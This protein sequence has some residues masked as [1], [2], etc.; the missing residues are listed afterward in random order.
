ML[1]VGVGVGVGMILDKANC[2]LSSWMEYEEEAADDQLSTLSKFQNG[3]ALSSSPLK[4][5]DD[6]DY[7]VRQS[8]GCLLHCK[9]T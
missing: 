2:E 9:S 5:A 7:V 3:V 1:L 4:L 8:A 6:Y